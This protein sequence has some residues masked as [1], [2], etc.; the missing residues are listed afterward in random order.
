MALIPKDSEFYNVINETLKEKLRNTT[1]KNN[2]TVFGATPMAY[3]KQIT[4][5]SMS[6]VSMSTSS[7]SEEMWE[8]HGHF[9]MN[10]RTS[11]TYDVKEL[12]ENSKKFKDLY[13][14]LIYTGCINKEE[15]D[16]FIK[17]RDKLEKNG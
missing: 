7:S 16:N 13:E 17:T 2:K 14:F 12:V 3:N 9:L 11:E 1:L 4:L 6:S 5:P 15:L 8:T 10:N